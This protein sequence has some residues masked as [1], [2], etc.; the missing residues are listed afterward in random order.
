MRSLFSLVL[1]V[2]AFGAS[3]QRYFFENVSVSNGLPASKVYAVLQDSTG[4]VWLATESGLASYDGLNVTSFDANSGMAPGGVRSLFIDNEKRLWCGHLGGGISVSQGRRFRTV[5]PSDKPL[6]ADVTTIS[7]DAS[8]AIWIGT[9]GMGLLRLKDLPDEGPVQMDRFE[10]SKGPG[11]RITS[12]VRRKNG[13]LV[14]LEAGLGLHLWSASKSQF[15]DYP[16][17]ELAEQQRI[18]SYFESSD[19]SFWVGTQEHGAVRFDPKTKRSTSYD[20]PTGMPSSFVYAFGEDEMGHVWIGTW[21]AGLVRVDKDGLRLFNKSN[22]LHSQTIRALSRDREGNLLIA[23]NDEG[24]EIFKGDRFRTFTDDDG[25]VERH[26]WAVTEGSDGRMWFGTNGGIT[27]L[28]P[29]STGPMSLQKLTVQNGDLTSNSVRALLNDGS[30]KIWIG[31]ENGGLL[32]A[33]SSGG[34]PIPHGELSALLGNNKVTALARCPSGGIYVGTVGGLIRL[35]P[36]GVPS[37]LRSSEGLAGNDVTALFNDSKG[38]T[39]VGTASSGVSVIAK[40]IKDKATPVDIGQVITPTSF[41]ED[42]AGHIWVGTTSQG[43]LIVENQKV[44][45]TFDVASGLLSNNV[46]SLITDANGHVWIGTN[47]GLNER[48]K[49]GSTFLAFTGRSGFTGIEANAGAVC[50]TRSGDLWFGTSNGADHVVIDHG[51]ERSELPLIAVRVL[52][53]GRASCRERV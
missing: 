32:E 30:G 27:I 47:L 23:T 38:N 39:W 31:T 9:F 46:R 53:I 24:L 13:D 48:K 17:S 22:G 33:S 8:G 20:L 42:A 35:V 41:T 2:L 6:T 16:E 3:A 12:I 45:G 4:L 7:Q 52:K 49:D 37:V 51:E 10:E 15:T 34:K 1:G 21:D 19:G 18:T 26:V 40:G 14:L 36:G 5:V 43:V 25:L 50:R 28:D 44:A 11:E 29:A